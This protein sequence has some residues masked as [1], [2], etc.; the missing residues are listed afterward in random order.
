MKPEVTIYYQ[1]SKEASEPSTA[2]FNINGTYGGIKLVGLNGSEIVHTGEDL[3]KK[4]SELAQ[5]N[6]GLIVRNRIPFVN[7]PEA[8]FLEVDYGDSINSYRPLRQQEIPE[9]IRTLIE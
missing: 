6:P 3:E 2:Y 4:V 5:N 8:T 9:S 7:I 1:E